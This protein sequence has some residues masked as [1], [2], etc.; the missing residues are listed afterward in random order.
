MDI[1]WTFIFACLL[2][3]H[4]SKRK[5]VKESKALTI[6]EKESPLSGLWRQDRKRERGRSRN[7]RR[8][9]KRRSGEHSGEKK[10]ERTLDN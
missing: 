9:R 10:E 2:Q 8:E 1:S 6:K 3:E 5:T 4:R 7:R